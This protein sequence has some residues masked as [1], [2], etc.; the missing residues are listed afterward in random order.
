M[1]QSRRHSLGLAAP[2]PDPPLASV[3]V[4]TVTGPVTGG[5][6]V[7]TLV[8]TTFD[9][10][11]VGYT[12]EEYLLSGVARTYT[13]TGA[14]TSD[15]RWTVRPTGSAPFVTRLV[16]FRPSDP[17][18]FNGTVMVEW[19]NVSPGFDC[20]PDWGSAH[21]A[22]IRGGFAW[23]GVSAQAVAVHGGTTIV[24]DAVPQ[25]LTSADPQRYGSLRHPGDSYSYDIYSQAGYVARASGVTDP[26]HGLAVARVIA[27]GESQSAYRLVTY[28]NAVQPLD[29]VYDGFLVHSRAGNA[30]PLSQPPQRSIRSPVP[31]MV[32]DDLDVPVLTFQTE[33][34]LTI[35]GYLPARQ[36][37]TDRF[38]LWEVAGTAHGDAYQSAFGLADIGDGAAEIEL[39]DV[40]AADGGPLGCPEPINYG[41][42]YAVLNAAVVQLDRWVRDGDPPPCAP[43][44]E[45]VPAAPSM[46]ARDERGNALGGIRTPLVDVPIATYSGEGNGGGFICE[47]YGTTIAF[48]D[49]TLAEL[50]PR[51]DA[52]VAAFAE[53]AAAAVET[54]FLLATDAEKLT[55]AAARST[56][57]GDR[58]AMPDSELTEGP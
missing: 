47:L 20:A 5:A 8:S 53:A 39:L 50:Y 34:D 58:G 48:D 27:I 4:A 49:A 29:R 55:T 9:L 6:G 10:G 21:N 13:A 28:I 51:H 18:R 12:T 35:L 2:G 31:T 38:R 41:P 56:I 40:A 24:G 44:L 46:I 7:P 36:P 26:L 57:G 15:G 14:L 11:S 32:R 43:R 19:L 30:A 33:S 54:G 45:I 1:T 52:Y 3:R 22:L 25:G 37:D 23:M 42:Q 17:D 16:V